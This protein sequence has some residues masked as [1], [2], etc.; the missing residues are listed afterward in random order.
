MSELDENTDSRRHL[1]WG[2]VSFIEAPSSF[3]LGLAALLLGGSL[4]ACFVASFFIK[5]DVAVKAQGVTDFMSGVKE[6]V[7]LTAGQVYYMS[8]HEGDV[9]A[10]DQTVAWIRMP[11]THEAQLRDLS[12]S[13]DNTLDRMSDTESAEKLGSIDFSF[14]EEPTLKSLLIDVQQKQTYFNRSLIDASDKNRRELAPIRRRKLIVGQQLDYI[15]KSKMKSYL[16]MQKQSLE[17][18]SGRLEQQITTANNALSNRIFDAKRETEKAIRL[19]QAALKSYVVAHQIKSPVSGTVG[20]LSVSVGGVVKDQQPVMTILPQDSPIVARVLVAS[21]DI[22]KV[23]E[24]LDVFVSVDS[25]PAHKYGYFK[26]RVLS[27]EKVIGARDGS[28]QAPD[29][30]TVRISLDSKSLVRKPAFDFKDGNEVHFLAG[31]NVEARIVSRR[32]SLISLGFDKL[33]GNDK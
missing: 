8:V 28:S 3:V 5:L 29:A 32:A 15:R 22:A 27:I 19:A 33:F 14:I 17:E 25:Y 10:K 30:Y 12:K 21:K 23:K 18:E 2:A 6:A 31:M 7:A 1:S 11:G 9:V 4:V 24:S 20:R 16:L 13:L 26:G